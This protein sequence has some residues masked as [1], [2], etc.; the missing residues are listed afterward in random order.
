MADPELKIA[1]DASGAIQQIQRL[2]RGFG[3]ATQRALSADELG[4]TLGQ[5][6][7]NFDDALQAAGTGAL[8]RKLWGTRLS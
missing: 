3:V 8:Q 6:D 4:A 5:L 1:A 2:G 7:K